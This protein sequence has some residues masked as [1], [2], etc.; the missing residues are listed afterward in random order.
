MQNLIVCSFFCFSPETPF[1]LS[2][3]FGKVISKSENCQ[4][5]LEFG[6]LSNSSMENSM[7]ICFSLEMHF[8]R[9]F[10]TKSKNC[11]LKLKIGT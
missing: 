10:V 11:Q 6:A 1:T 3:P 4:F 5:E 9:K 7:V 8:L 2:Y